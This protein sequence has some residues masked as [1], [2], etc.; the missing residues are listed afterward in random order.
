MK[1]QF[2]YKEVEILSHALE[3]Y[4]QYG[5]AVNEDRA[6]PSSIDGLKPVARRALWV[7]FEKGA[8]HKANYSKSAAFVG[9][10]FAAGT[11]VSTPDGDIEIESL[12]IGDLVKTSQGD[13][14]VIGLIENPPTLLYH[15]ELQDGKS[16]VLTSNQEVKIIIEGKFFWKKA[17]DLTKEDEIV[18]EG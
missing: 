17:K 6:I 11:L 12:N 13:K 16:V 3:D 9:D 5:T 2:Q 14:K 15:L 8:T 1:E 4:Y 18:V 10:C 7:T